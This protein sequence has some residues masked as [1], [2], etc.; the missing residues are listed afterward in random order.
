MFGKMMV[1]QRTSQGISVLP[2]ESLSFEQRTIYIDGEINDEM[3]AEFVKQ[4][5]ML[6]RM[7]AHKTIKVLIMS[8]GGSVIHG[9]AM[10]DA[11]CT[12]TAPI[13]TYCI[14]TAYSM[15]AIL[16]VAG[17]KRF[18]LEHSKIMLHEPLI[19]NGYMG[20]ASSIKS[21]S[22]SLQD[23]KKQLST[24]LCKHTGKDLD[25]MNQAINYDHYFSAAEAVDFGLADEIIGLDR[26]I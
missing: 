11:I 24:I 12:S 3:A 5:I 15:A 14:G 8:A 17:R 20:S 25:E 22:D 4:I 23:T 21:M 26:V 18:L 10:Y 6:N 7:D 2:L 16:F 13:D 1:P 9:L 19:E